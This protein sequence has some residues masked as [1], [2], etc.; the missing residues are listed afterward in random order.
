MTV[1]LG[2][3]GTGNMAGTMIGAAKTIPGLTVIGVA[4]ASG[5]ISRSQSLATNFGIRHA[6]GSPE[7]LLARD[8]VDL[9]YIA[10]G[11]HSHVSLCLAALRA[12]KSVL[13]EKPF[14]T[15]IEEANVVAADARR[16]GRLF[17]EALWTLL[18]PAYRRTVEIVQKGEIG[19]PTHLTASFGY[20]NLDADSFGRRGGVLLDR[21]VYPISLAITLLGPV[22]HV[23][24][25]I[26]NNTDGVD[27]DAELQLFHTS[28]ARSQLAVSFSSLLSNSAV[29]SGPGGAVTLESPLLGS[30]RITIRHAKN[31]RPASNL[32]GHPTKQTLREKLKAIPILRRLQGRLLDGQR[33]YHCYGA[34]LYHP[35]L[36]HVVSLVQSGKNNSD[37]ACLDLSLAVAKVIDLARKASANTNRGASR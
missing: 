3:I 10:T 1:R 21:A 36:K 8:D 30:E 31:D 18:L 5:S 26:A 2:V 24:A 6:Y 15:S 16:S 25:A 29:V 35:L 23:D 33:E 12:E 27:V 11:L 34:N 32:R 19:R 7:S 20:P 4:S 37:V 22:E 9:I 14:A 28:G 13:C 17:M